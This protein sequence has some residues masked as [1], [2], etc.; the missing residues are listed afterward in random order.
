MAVRWFGDSAPKQIA[1]YRWRIRGRAATESCEQRVLYPVVQRESGAG[2][3]LTN[4]PIDE[5]RIVERLIAAL[6]QEAS[7]PTPDAAAFALTAHHLTGLLFA[8]F[9]VE[10]EVLLPVLDQAMIPEQFQREVADK[11]AH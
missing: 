4:V 8:H 11:M 1:H 10:E 3:Q 2:S 6:E 5:H 7:K 9:E